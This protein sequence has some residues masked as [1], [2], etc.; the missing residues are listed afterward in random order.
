MDESPSQIVKY[1]NRLATVAMAEDSGFEGWAKTPKVLAQWCDNVLVE[2]D[3]PDEIE[4]EDEA[5]S[6]AESEAEAS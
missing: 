2:W 6:E 3:R 4:A 1:S 5:E